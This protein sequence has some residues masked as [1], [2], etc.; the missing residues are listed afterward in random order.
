MSLRAPCCM[1]DPAYWLSTNFW[2]GAKPVVTFWFNYKTYC[3]DISRKIVNQF[4]H[5]SLDNDGSV[6]HFV[7]MRADFLF[8]VFSPGCDSGL[9]FNFYSSQY[10]QTM[11][12]LPAIPTIH[13]QLA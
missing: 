12:Y 8:V 6:L 1:S 10:Y 7:L 9:P 13:I 5:L 11:G 3:L 4:L 2:F